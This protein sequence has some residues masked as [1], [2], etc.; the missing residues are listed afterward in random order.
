M[1][2]LIPRTLHRR[3]YRVAHALRRLWWR[4][5]KPRVF[6][7]RILAFDSAGRVLLV[8]HSYGSA[9][10]M[11]PGGSL[12]R[13]EDALLGAT[14]ELAEEIGCRLDRAW[15]VALTEEPL[16][17][18]TNVVSVVAGDVA[19]TP[20]PDEREVIEA[21]F[22]APDALPQPMSAALRRDL[23]A[24]LRAAKAGRP[25]PPPTDSDFP[26]PTG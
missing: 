25:A 7:C 23:P 13:G 4:T 10:W 9:H 16:H 18:A 6:G 14:R 21:V 2:H 17:G 8:R 15:Q 19:G 22:F 3:A 26:G 5:C 11:A 12:R 20:K 1:L 24:W